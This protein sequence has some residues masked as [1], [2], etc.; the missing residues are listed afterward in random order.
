[1]FDY[2][3]VYNIGFLKS[4]WSFHSF[5]FYCLDA[6]ENVGSKLMLMKYL[7]LGGGEKEV[8]YVEVDFF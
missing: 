3:R 4:T 7:I 6:N 1:M 8:M 5:N 2:D